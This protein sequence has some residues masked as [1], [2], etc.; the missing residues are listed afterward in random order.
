[1]QRDQVIEWPRDHRGGHP[2][3]LSPSQRLQDGRLVLTEPSNLHGAPPWSP[4]PTASKAYLQLSEGKPYKDPDCPAPLLA[5]VGLGSGLYKAHSTYRSGQAIGVVF[6]VMDSY[7]LRTLGRIDH[8]DVMLAA[9]HGLTVA[10]LRQAQALGAAAL[11]A[12][13]ETDGATSRRRRASASTRRR[14]GSNR[15]TQAGAQARRRVGAG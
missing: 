4:D 3:P 12:D 6:K 14:V 10:E 1:M 15:P 2:R 5:N 8:K 9:H 7:E 13:D 11:A